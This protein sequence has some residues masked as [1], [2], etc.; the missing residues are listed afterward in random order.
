MAIVSSTDGSPTKTC[1]KRRSS[2]ASFS[3][4]SRYSSR[5]VAPHH[6]QL[7]AGQHRLEHAAGVHGALG[8]PRPTTVCSSSMKVMIWPSLCLISFSTALRRS[9]N[10]PRYFEPAT[11]A[12]RSSATSRLPRSDSRHVPRHDPLGQALDHRGLADPG[13][14]DQDRVVLGPAGQHP[15]SPAGSRRPGRSPG[16]DPPRGARWVKSTPYFSSA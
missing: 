9:S 3:I 1:W 10:S 4:R 2:A 13:L 14:A 12:P 11:I 7:A 15:G 8:R 6:P 5:V 16:R